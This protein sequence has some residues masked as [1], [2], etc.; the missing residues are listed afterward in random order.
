MPDRNRPMSH[1]GSAPHIRTHA[2][3]REI[4]APM[5][6]ASAVCYT[7]KWSGSDA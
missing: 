2:G 3:Y 5:P 4:T 7:P 6:V 1:A